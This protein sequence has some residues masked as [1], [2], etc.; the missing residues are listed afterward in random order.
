MKLKRC[1]RDENPD[2]P[3]EMN[4]KKLDIGQPLVSYN[5]YMKSKGRIWW[6]K[7]PSFS[8]PPH[9]QLRMC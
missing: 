5:G 9:D 3:W 7:V 6:D 4:M 8:S 1:G 2:S